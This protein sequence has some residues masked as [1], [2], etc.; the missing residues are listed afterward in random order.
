M[1][2]MTYSNPGL[3]IGQHVGGPRG[4]LPNGARLLMGHTRHWE[5]SNHFSMLAFGDV[6]TY[7]TQMPWH[8]LMGAQESHLVRVLRCPLSVLTLSCPKFPSGTLVH[9]TMYK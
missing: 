8:T 3:W 5:V 9:L 2:D 6:L 1:Y 7:T 4:S